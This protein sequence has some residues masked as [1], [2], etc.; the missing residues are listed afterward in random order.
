MHA[1]LLFFVELDALE[2]FATP[3]LEIFLVTD[4][5]SFEAI[6]AFIRVS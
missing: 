6:I 4:S 1:D 3:S 5:G 2:Q